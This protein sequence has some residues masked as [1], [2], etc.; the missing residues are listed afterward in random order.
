M[1]NAVNLTFVTYSR[2]LDDIGGQVL[3]SLSWSSQPPRSS[4]D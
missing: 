3:S 4:S 2:M 1:L